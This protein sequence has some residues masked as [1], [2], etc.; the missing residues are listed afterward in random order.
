MDLEQLLPAGVRVVSIEPKQEK[1]RVEVKFTIG[2]TSNEAKLKF[3][4]ALEDSKNFS[5]V[6]LSG[7]HV[8]TVGTGG[9]PIVLELTA[10]YSRS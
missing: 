9:D 8:S 4:K 7:T 2:A 6:Q 5:R 1:G 10:E 3:I